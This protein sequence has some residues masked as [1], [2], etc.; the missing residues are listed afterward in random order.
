[1]LVTPGLVASMIGHLRGTTLVALE[2]SL[3][4]STRLSSPPPT[5]TAT[6]PQSRSTRPLRLIPRPC[7]GSHCGW[8]SALFCT[9]RKYSLLFDFH[10]GGIISFC[11]LVS[12]CY[13]HS[14]MFVT[15]FK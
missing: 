5:S 14:F 6:P 15:Q 13:L 10:V 1:M 3:D 12:W 9:G 11:G 8:S 2:G 4:T 7:G